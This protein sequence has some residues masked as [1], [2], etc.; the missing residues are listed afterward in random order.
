MAAKEV[1]MGDV[2]RTIR[3][4]DRE[5]MD[6][7]AAKN[8]ARRPWRGFRSNARLALPILSLL[9]HWIWWGAILSKHR[10]QGGDLSLG[11]ESRESHKLIF[12]CARQGDSI[13]LIE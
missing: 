10:V 3:T 12:I 13:R 4:M 2:V 11:R 1:A 6:N 5:F 8:A 9:W 7:L